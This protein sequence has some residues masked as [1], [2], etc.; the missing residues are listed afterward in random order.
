M[1][2]YSSRKTR[3]YRFVAVEAAHIFIPK[4]SVNPSEVVLSYWHADAPDALQVI[5]YSAREHERAEYGISREDKR[6]VRR[7][8]TV[9]PMR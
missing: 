8:R 6:V 1:V 7:N 4:S 2:N 9:P 3:A 5:P